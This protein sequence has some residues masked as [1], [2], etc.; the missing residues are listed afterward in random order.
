MEGPLQISMV[1]TI[2]RETPTG[3]RVGNVGVPAKQHIEYI[4]KNRILGKFTGKSY[5]IE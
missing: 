2:A 1:F 4:N 5:L 3:I